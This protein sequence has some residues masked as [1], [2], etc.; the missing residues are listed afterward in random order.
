MLA[1]E[2]PLDVNA[3][4]PN[5]EAAVGVVGFVVSGV[6]VAVVII[7]FV[8]AERRRSRRRAH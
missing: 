5:N 4:D 2:D 3:K 7:L 1:G 6:L 8:R